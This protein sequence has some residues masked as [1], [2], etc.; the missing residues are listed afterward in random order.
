MGHARCIARPGSRGA[1]GTSKTTVG[2]AAVTITMSDFQA[3]SLVLENTRKS[4][5]AWQD[6][7]R[8]P[9]LTVLLILELAAIFL[10]TPLAA[11]GLPMTRAITDTLVLGVLGIVVMLSHRLGAIIFIL[12]GLAVIAASI[13][14]SGEWSPVSAPALRREGDILVFCALIWEVAHAVYADGPITSY[15]LQGAVVLYLSLATVFAAA[16]GLIWE[17][18]PSAFVYLLAPVGSPKEVAT[19]LYFSLTTLTTTGYGTSL[20]SILSLAA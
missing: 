13:L 5:H 18:N 1:I 17:L 2:S 12:L 11:E 19:M 3:P 7:I 15:R 6:R 4:I 10:A 16:Y 20:R 14:H 9:S 8:D